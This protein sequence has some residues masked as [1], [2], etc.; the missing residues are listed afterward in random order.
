MAEKQKGR[1][2]IDRNLIIGSNLELKKII[3]SFYL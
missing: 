1:I 2:D 3:K